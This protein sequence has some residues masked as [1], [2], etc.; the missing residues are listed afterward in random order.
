VFYDLAD[1][2]PGDDVLVTRKDGATVTFT[3]DALRDVQKSRFPTELV[4]GAKDLST[5]RLRLITCSQFDP[6]LGTHVGNTV[7]FATMTGVE[8]A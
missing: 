8:R 5:P 2:R 4:Y 3:V 7:V 6:D 1:I